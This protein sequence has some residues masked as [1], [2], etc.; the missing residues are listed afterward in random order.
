MGRL[1]YS[2]SLQAGAVEN[3]AT[4]QA[5]LEEAQTAINN[6][7]DEQIA[8]GANIDYSKLNLGGRIEDSDIASD[9]GIQQSKLEQLSI[10]NAEIADG[11]LLLEKLE[12]EAIRTATNAS[13]IELTTS[14]QNIVAVTGMDAGVWLALAQ[15]RFHT[16]GLSVGDVLYSYRFVNLF[17]AD[18]TRSHHT[19]INDEDPTY[20]QV[21]LVGIFTAASDGNAITVQAMSEINDTGVTLNT[22]VDAGQCDIWCFRL[23]GV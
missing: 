22:Y 6:I 8:S 13:Q 17:A 16:D 1:V 21:T 7:I 14:M 20:T 19:Y 15:M 3:I 10:G 4:V 9:A 11:D 5:M 23:R 12:T 18:G 2:T